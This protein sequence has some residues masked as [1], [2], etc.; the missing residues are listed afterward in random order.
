MAIFTWGEK[1]FVGIQSIDR[2]HEKLVDYINRL[3]D[4]ML[5]GA[6]E[7]VLGPILNG[8][9]NYTDSHFKYEEQLFRLHDYPASE[10]HFAHHKKLVEQV[11]KFKNDFDNGDADITNEMMN[12]LKD[13]L[14]DHILKE[15]KKYSPFFLEKGVK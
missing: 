13:W 4:G 14:M 12:F 8:L 11:L 5:T 9:I 7:E 3:H 10:E 1:F 6:G 15:D 2:Q